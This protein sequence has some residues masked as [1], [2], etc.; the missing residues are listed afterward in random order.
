[1]AKVTRYLKLKHPETGKIVSIKLGE[2]KIIDSVNEKY[3]ILSYGDNLTDFV[4][5]VCLQF[6]SL[7]LNCFCLK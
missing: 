6:H 5:L 7:M 4:Y 2:V 1:M 3:T